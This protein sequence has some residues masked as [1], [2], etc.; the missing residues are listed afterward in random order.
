ME[1]NR[2]QV[3]GRRYYPTYYGR[4]NTRHSYRSYYVGGTIR[5]RSADYVVGTC[6]ASAPDGWVAGVRGGYAARTSA[7]L[8]NLPNFVSA[9]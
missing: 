7:A 9:K 2:K 6:D 3:I 1:S 8:N 4:E 5:S